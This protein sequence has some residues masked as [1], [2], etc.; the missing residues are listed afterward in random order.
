MTV[1]T[2]YAESI[3]PLPA[4]DRLRLATLILGDIPPQ[5]VIDY[6]EE[7]TEEDLA[8]FTGQGWANLE[9]QEKSDGVAA[10]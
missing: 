10:G 7:W 2:L 4:A 3:K 6:S 9:E 8:D 1:E 5:S